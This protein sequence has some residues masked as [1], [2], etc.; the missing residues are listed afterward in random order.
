M[1]EHLPIYGED[2]VPI[3]LILAAICLL[4]WWLTHVAGYRSSLSHQ[5][6]K[7]VFA[8]YL[9]IL[10]QMTVSLE[11][12]WVNFRS[13]QWT[14]MGGQ[15]W[16][17][18]QEIRNFWNHGTD[19]LI[20]TNLLGNVLLFVPMGVLPP[21]LW[22]WCRWPWSMALWAVIPSCVIEFCQL[23]TPRATSVDDVILNAAG[24]VVGY[25]LFW[26]LRLCGIGKNTVVKRGKG[27]AQRNNEKR[28]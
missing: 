2:F 24:V 6:V 11:S 16:T 5:V 3:C 14:V 23:F 8:A 21:L 9:L 1:L 15:M 12:L 4:E 17:P 18:F 10:F 20:L 13:G 27:K 7:V 19:E 25:L 28:T 26:F 22:K